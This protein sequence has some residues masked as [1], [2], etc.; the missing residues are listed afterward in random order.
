MILR[1][2]LAAMA[3][4]D[5]GGVAVSTA[6]LISTGDR[7]MALYAAGYGY[8]AAICGLAAISMAI[9]KDGGGS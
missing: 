6:A 1:F 7:A 4:Y 2:S 5:L 8:M 9:P 3:L